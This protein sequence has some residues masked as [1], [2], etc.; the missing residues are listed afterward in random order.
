[1]VNFLLFSQFLSKEILKSFFFIVLRNLNDC[2]S[3]NLLWNAILRQLT[4]TKSHYLCT[5]KQFTQPANGK[6]LNA[7]SYFN[8]FSKIQTRT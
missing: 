2:V 5:I 8:Y 6:M 3:I 7:S 4:L 1:M